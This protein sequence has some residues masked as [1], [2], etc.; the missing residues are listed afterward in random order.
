MKLNNYDED[1]V[2]KKILLVDDNKPILDLLNSM[3][4]SYGIEV[5]Y[6]A[7][8]GE[9]AFDIFCAVNPDVV[10][11]DYSME[12]VDGMELTKNIRTH[13]DSPNPG[14]PIILV[15]SFSERERVLEARDSG[16]NEFLVKPINSEALYARLKYVLENPRD[17]V[18]KDSYIGPDRRRNRKNEYQG[19]L[20]RDDDFGS[21]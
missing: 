7:K 11:S 6:K 4:M 3:L 18:E 5:V 19:P 1:L 14:V 21:S 8:N 17:F 16:V 2:D 12:P 10:I 9:Q 20:R 15:T 13:F